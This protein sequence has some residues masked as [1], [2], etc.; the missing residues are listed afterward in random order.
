VT[1]QHAAETIKY[2]HA[3]E[4]LPGAQVEENGTPLMSDTGYWS[5]PDSRTEHLVHKFS[6]IVGLKM[7]NWTSGYGDGGVFRELQEPP[8]LPPPGL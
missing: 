5:S 6:S 2:S 8:W 1:T 7:R 4:G 3:V